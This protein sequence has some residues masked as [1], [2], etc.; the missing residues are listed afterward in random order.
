MARINTKK[1]LFDYENSIKKSNELS[2]A[3]LNQGLS[4][5][6]MQ[7]LA[8]AIYSTQ[9]D[10]KTEFHKSDFEKKFGL[11]KYNTEDA[12][13]DSD[14]ILGL[15][16]SM[17]DLENDKFKFWNAFSSMEYS[18]GVFSFK[19]NQEMLS[20]ILELKEKYVMTDLTVTAKFKSSFSWTLY[21]YLKA[22]YGYWHKP[23]SKESLMKL[24][25]VENRKTYQ[26]NTGKFKSTV[27]DVAIEEINTYTE[28]EVRYEEEKKGRSIIGFDLIW[29]NGKNVKS[30]TKKQIKELK[31]ITS[32][33][34]KD[35]FEFVNLNN[36][37]NRKKA[38]E[39]IRETNMMK[40]YTEDPVCITFEKA[41][42]LLFHA[43]DNLRILSLML[44]KETGRDTS[45]YYNWL[46]EK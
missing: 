4:L 44:E 6:Q 26:N 10:G 20:H 7:L 28:L 14:R 3:K 24:F 45:F 2:M 16:V 11:S 9:Q 29:S 17:Q 40:I 15:R 13:E 43:N 27:L 42:E 38:I 1:Q 21:D 34:T 32:T 37:E 35:M 31:R 46:E 12:Y 5:N 30:A 22:H 8:Y 39:L 36:S 25:G 19:W 18:K 23:I 41:D 33:I